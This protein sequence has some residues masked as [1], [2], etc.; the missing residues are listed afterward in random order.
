MKIEIRRIKIANRIRKEITKIEELAED[1][2]KNG[3][4]CPIA[5]MPLENN[6]YQLLAGLRRLK[7]LESI[8]ETTIEANIIPVTDAE[9]ALNIEFSENEQREDFTYTEKMDYIAL[10]EEIER[11]K[12]KGRMSE[13]G[14]GGLQEGLIIL[15]DLPD[16]EASTTK[17]R[18]N[19]DAI[20][21]PKIGM[22]EA[23]YRR[24]KYIANNAPQEI[25][26]ELDRGERSINGT[27]FELRAAEKA[28]DHPEIAMKKNTAASK[29]H[30]S[31]TSVA[32]SKPD[33]ITEL[34]E[35]YQAALNRAASAE[36]D[37]QKLHET[38]HNDVYHRDSII[39]NLQLRNEKLDTELTKAL[40]TVASLKA[41]LD[42]ANARIKEL[43][44]IING[45]TH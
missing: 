17:N 40:E 27:Y 15:S 31:K 30:E 39:E 5:I 7:A 19:V 18:G 14:K 20:V 13:G 28:N 1:I 35:G 6:E 24:A 33:K 42:A 37:L 25:I 22:S 23:T 38:N 3:L 26:D 32:F 43:E 16:K 10:F 8:G 2:Q 9:A 44:G 12:A 45:N 4:I 34:Q 29:P 41:A 11:A 21:A 36:S